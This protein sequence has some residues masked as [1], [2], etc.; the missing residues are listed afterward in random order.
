MTWNPYGETKFCKKWW[1]RHLCRIWKLV[2]VNSFIGLL[3]IC[4][5]N[6]FTDTNSWIFLTRIR[7]SRWKSVKQP[8]LPNLQFKHATKYVH[9]ILL[10][11]IRSCIERF[12]H[13]R[14]LSYR[15]YYFSNF[16]F[17]T[18]IDILTSSLAG[19]KISYAGDF[20]WNGHLEWLW[21]S[22]IKTL[23]W[24][25][26]KIYYRFDFLGAERKFSRSMVFI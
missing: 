10:E 6:I 8:R 25:Y 26:V 2:S 3:S 21:K 23:C 20:F 14:K 19:F 9:Y 22:L 13:V 16:S 11:A 15:K 18:K 7:S 4:S 24:T 12:S 17:F 5:I 1:R